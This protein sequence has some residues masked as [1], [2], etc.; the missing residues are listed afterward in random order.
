MEGQYSIFDYMGPKAAARTPH[1]NK[2]T[3]YYI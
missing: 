2:P 1:T 3:F